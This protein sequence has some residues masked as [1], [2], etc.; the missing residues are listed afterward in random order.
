MLIPPMASPLSVPGVL[1]EP[2]HAEI[3]ALLFRDLKDHR[4]W[5]ALREVDRLSNLR[6]VRCDLSVPRGRHAIAGSELREPPVLT[7]RSPC[8]RTGVIKSDC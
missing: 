7:D 6:C 2:I 5:G 8:H 3:V 4:Y 1:P